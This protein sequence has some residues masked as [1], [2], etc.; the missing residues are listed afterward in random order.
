[1][2]LLLWYY[3]GI[4]EWIRRKICLNMVIT[5]V[6]PFL[7]ILGVLLSVVTVL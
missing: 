2:G 6:G 1:M 5:L 4:P 3:L 7:T